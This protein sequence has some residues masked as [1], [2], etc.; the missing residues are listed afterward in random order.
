MRARALTAVV[1]V[2][3]ATVGAAA[4]AAAETGP[5]G[6]GSIDSEGN[7]TASAG[8]GVA[9]G[10]GS[11]GG[12]DGG[13]APL[14]HWEVVIEDDL[15]MSIYS[16]DTLD[17]LHSRTGRWLQYMCDDYGPV[18]ID[19]FFLVPEG[20]LVDPAALAAEALSSVGI[21][22]PTIRTSPSEQGR[23]YVRVPTWLWIERG[24]WRPYEATATAGRVT[25]TV[26][27]R[28]TAA[29]WSLGYGAEVQC[30]GPGRAWRRG[31]PERATDCSHTYTRASQGRGDGRF[32]LEA[33][34]TLEVSWTSNIGAGGTLPAISRSSSIEVV[35]GEIQAV[36]TN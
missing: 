13:S 10:A 24:W 23:L 15:R 21:G 4:P 2:V 12:E 30:D 1:F 7:P 28:P 29:S 18:P 33:T 32:S 9:A 6:G 14:C 22:G 34:V 25:A 8:D 20:G 11:P 31:L 27:A 5:Y 36:G 19:G 3:V 35:V 16:V 26:V 17:T